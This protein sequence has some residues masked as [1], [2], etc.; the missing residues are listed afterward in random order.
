MKKTNFDPQPIKN[1]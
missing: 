1:Q